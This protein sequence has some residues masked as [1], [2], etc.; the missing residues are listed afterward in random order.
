MRRLTGLEKD[1][2]K[3]E[4]GGRGPARPWRGIVAWSV[5][6]GSWV[7][8]FSLRPIPEWGAL[9]LLGGNGVVLLVAYFRDLMDAYD[10]RGSD[11][12]DFWW[13]RHP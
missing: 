13:L 6:V 4:S 9:A 1:G 10:L 2:M 7:T 5:V 11:P 3:E 12:P 8:A